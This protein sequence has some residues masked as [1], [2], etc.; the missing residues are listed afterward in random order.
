MINKLKQTIAI[1]FTSLI[2]ES[3]H[4]C[5]MSKKCFQIKDGSYFNEEGWR[6]DPHGYGDV[7]HCEGLRSYL[8]QCK[9]LLYLSL[10]FYATSIEQCSLLQV[11]PLLAT[12]QKWISLPSSFAIL[13]YQCTS[14]GLASFL[15]LFPLSFTFSIHSTRMSGLLLS[16]YCSQC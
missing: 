12:P 3:D 8:W 1:V 9:L 5:E 14:P 10:Y 7:L 11:G 2:N 4:Y 13:S 15:F 16:L 6:M